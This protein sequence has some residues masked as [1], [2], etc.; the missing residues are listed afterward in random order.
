MRAGEQRWLMKAIRE[1]GSEMESRFLALPDGAVR[2]RFADDEW[3]LVEVLGHVRD[4]EQRCLKQLKRMTT[5]RFPRLP[6]VDIVDWPIERG[7]AQESLHHFTN[8]FGNLREETVQT[9]WMLPD[10]WAAYGGEHPYLGA[11]TLLDLIR[12]LNRHDL[13]H[14]WQANRLVNAY[15]QMQGLPTGALL[16]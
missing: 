8:E 14:L 7:Y 9:L 1:A 10:D 15:E 3:C 16:G 6:H 12:E 5:E 4:Y 11:V 2:W 13:T